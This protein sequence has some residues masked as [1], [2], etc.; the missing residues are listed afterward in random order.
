M[1]SQKNGARTANTSLSTDQS[2][3]RSFATDT[4]IPA[5]NANTSLQEQK[6]NP[7]ITF[8]GTLLGAAAG[9]AIAYAVAQDNPETSMRDLK[10]IPHSQKMYQ[11]LVNPSAPRSATSSRRTLS[12]NHSTVSPR[13][14]QCK[15]H[16]YI[17]TPDSPRL[18]TTLVKALNPHSETSRSSLP[19]AAPARPNLN[20]STC[21]EILPPHSPPS[22]PGNARSYSSSAKTVTRTDLIPLPLSHASSRYTTSH[23]WDDRPASNHSHK[24]RGNVKTKGLN[25]APKAD[26]LG[27]IA[28]CDS[29]SQVGSKCEKRS[30][31]SRVRSRHN[32][33]PRNSGSQG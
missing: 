2:S 18:H 6:S 13:S 29:I 30:N 12:L 16:R 3:L 11:A 22:R 5:T 24:G 10:P 26:E 33:G 32:D 28:P 9:A 4:A 21:S 25:Q 27:S 7:S 14:S 20:R 19:L 23:F 1:T 17:E 31:G 15:D 8:I